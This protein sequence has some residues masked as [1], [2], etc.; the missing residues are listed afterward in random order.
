MLHRIDTINP[1][2][3]WYNEHL[4]ISPEFL[5]DFIKEARKKH[6]SFI[7]IDELTEIINKKKKCHRIIAITLDDGYK[8]NYI[9]GLPLFQTFNVPFCIYISTKIPE[10]CMTYWWY[11]IED[12]ILQQDKSIKLSNGKTFPCRTKDEKELA[13]LSVREEVL[14]LPQE[15]FDIVF[16]NLLNQYQ[17]NLTTYNTELPLTWSMIYKIAKEPLATIGSHTHSHISMSGCNKEMILHDIKKSIELLKTKA[18]V[19][20]KHFAYPYGDNIAVKD[21]HK[22]IVKELGF[23]TIAST[24][25]GTLS[26]HTD[27]LEL[28]RIFITEHNAYNVLDH[29]TNIC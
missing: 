27:P 3:L 16:Q 20:T 22:E 19:L 5:E 1:E 23:Y 11:L 13:F 10:Q 12:I 24:Q 7:S 9:N 18:N 15:R 25:E 26:Y 4:K 21:F 29:L 8:D 28:P 14:K 6:F 17:V 2:R